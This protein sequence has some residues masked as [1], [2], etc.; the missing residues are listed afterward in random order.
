MS[1]NKI[2]VPALRVREVKSSVGIGAAIT[3]Y[4]RIY[5]SEF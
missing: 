5:I 1:E 2:K 4:A 3:V